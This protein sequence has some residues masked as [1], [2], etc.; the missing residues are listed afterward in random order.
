MK[1]ARAHGTHAAGG[2]PGK[3]GDSGALAAGAGRGG[4]VAEAVAAEPFRVASAAAAPTPLVVGDKMD[5]RGRREV[6]R[7]PPERAAVFFFS[8]PRLLSDES[9]DLPAACLV[10]LGGNRY[11]G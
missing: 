7:K 11:V 10:R 9:W 2:Y 8:L 4:G 6:G 3:F 5:L 1:G